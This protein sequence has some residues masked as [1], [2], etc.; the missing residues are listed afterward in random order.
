MA[1][2]LI[3]FPTLQKVLGEFAIEVRNRYQDSLINNDRIASGGLLN[4]IDYITKF[5]DRE[6]SVSLK[7]ADY[8]KWVEYDTKPHFPPMDKILEWVKIK[9]VLPTP[10]DGKLPTPQQ[11]A[12]LI[13]RKISEDGTKGTHDLQKSVDE[14]WAEFQERVYQAIDADIDK[15]TITLFTEWY[16]KK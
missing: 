12:Y 5:G 8:W 13:G 1:D 11:L 7:M 15:A 2:E 4:S 6:Y 10:S 16:D 3:S 14:V 9:P